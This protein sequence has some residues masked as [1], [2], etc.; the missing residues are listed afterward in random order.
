MA[1]LLKRNAR[2][3]WI[4]LLPVDFYPAKHQLNAARAHM[5]MNE[6]QPVSFP[7]WKAALAEIRVSIITSG[8]LCYW[9]VKARVAALGGMMTVSWTAVLVTEPRE[10]VANSV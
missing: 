1:K 10:F 3:R 2:F 9:T 4:E 6:K 5:C 7:G 8:I